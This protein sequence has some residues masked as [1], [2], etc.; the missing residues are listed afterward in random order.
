MA[1]LL[2]LLASLC[3][4]LL[5]DLS[6]AGCG[7]FVGDKSG[8]KYNLDPL[9][10]AVD[11]QGKE[12]AQASYTYWYNFCQ[13]INKATSGI[14]CTN[15]T[16][17]A[18]V[19]NTG[20]C[21]SVGYLPP[22]IKELDTKNGVTM[23]YTNNNDLCGNPKTIPRVSSFILNCA[24]KTEY[25]LVG[26]D[27]PVGQVCQYRFTINTKYACPGGGG[28]S[29]TGSS[30]GGKHSG[31]VGPG[32][33]FIIIFVCVATVYFAAGAVVKWKVYNANGVELVPN[34]ELWLGL[35][36]LI[37]DGFLFVKNKI[38]G[39]VGYSSL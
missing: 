31:G 11:Y 7:T 2:V 6:D 8:A 32:W 37:R 1:K 5:V 26:I 28:S 20:T 29:N 36:G 33:V 16:P 15:P 14:T 24:A 21:I 38:T 17:T 4:A 18:Q 34:T 19:S 35:P 30:S 12:A 39:A 13:N 23:V 27:E 9:T 25:E 22:D 10:K 3:L